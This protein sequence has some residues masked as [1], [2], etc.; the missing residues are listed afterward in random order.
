MSVSKHVINV[1]KIHAA[2]NNM[3]IMYKKIA[4]G[5]VVI[6]SL[7]VIA[8]GTYVLYNTVMSDVE[9]R[10]KNAVADGIKEGLLNTINPLHWPQALIEQYT[11]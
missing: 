7:C 5:I 4:Y 9:L 8:Y 2:N 1:L 3:M 10:I 6:G 11:R